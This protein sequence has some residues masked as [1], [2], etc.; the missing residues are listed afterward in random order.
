MNAA[1]DEKR[2]KFALCVLPT[3]I[4]KT[5]QV[6][7]KI[8]MEMKQDNILGKSIHIIFTMNTLL[9]NTQFSKR[10]QHVEGEKKGSVCVVSSKCPGKYIHFKF[11][12]QLL[13]YCLRMKT[14]PSVI[15]MCGNK[16]RFSDGEQIMKTLDENRLF[17]ISRVFAYYDELHSYINDP[18]RDQIERIHVLD[19]VSGITALTASPDKIWKNTGFWNNIRLLELDNY[20]DSNYVGFKDMMFNCIDDFFDESS[21][22]IKWSY[23][24]ADKQTVGYIKHVLDRFP[25]ILGDNTRS[26]IPAHIRRNGH[27]SVRDLIFLIND[28]AVVIVINGVQKTLE[29]KDSVGNIKTLPLI[30]NKKENTKVEEVCETISRLV[31]KHKLENRPIVITGLLCV[32]MGQTLAHKALGSFTSTIFGHLDLTNDDLYQLF[33]RITGRMKD[34]G[35]KYIQTQVYC[36]TT[37]MN[38]INAMEECVINMVFHNGEAVSQ[39]DY[40]YPMKEMGEIGR[41]SCRERV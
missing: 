18:L 9:N 41:A 12:D 28:K 35:D 3:Q 33:G 1:N 10:L 11:V 17:D 26:F 30:T 36:P 6:V 19:I 22:Q 24:E 5:F 27:N 4:G 39:E 32:G 2:S 21:S 34:W 8:G 20:N 38:R 16:T 13:G 14:C 23:D 25:E 37:I 40:R 29:Y 7:S 31:L 15:V